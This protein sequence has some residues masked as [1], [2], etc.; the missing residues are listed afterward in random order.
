MNGYLIQIGEAKAFL[1]YLR[2]SPHVGDVVQG[3][4]FGTLRVSQRVWLPS[5]E[6]VI[7]VT[8]E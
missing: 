6:L 4:K 3:T 7:R 5:G 1:I 2:E 8:V